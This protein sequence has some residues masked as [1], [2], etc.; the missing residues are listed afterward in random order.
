MPEDLAF[1]ESESEDP[2]A[3]GE[4]R[5]ADAATTAALGDIYQRVSQL[6]PIDQELLTFSSGTTAL[7]GMRKLAEHNFSQAPVL[8]AE[9]CVGVFS[10]TVLLLARLPPFPIARPGLMKSLSQIA[11]EAPLFS[12]R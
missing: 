12:A 6:V 5:F 3:V 11:P 9:K 10:C 7:E 1:E 8:H 2:T 4:A